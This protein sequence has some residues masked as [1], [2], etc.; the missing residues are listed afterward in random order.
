MADVY[1]GY[2]AIVEHQDFETAPIYRYIPRYQLFVGL[3]LGL[4]MLEIFWPQRRTR[5]HKGLTEILFHRRRDQVVSR[6]NKLTNQNKNQNDRQR[7]AA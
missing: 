6:D 7:I 4:L 2:F 5:S 1:H 3:C